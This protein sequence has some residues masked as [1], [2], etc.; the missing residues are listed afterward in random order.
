MPAVSR[1]QRVAAAI[2]EHEPEKLYTRNRGMLSMGKN[3]LSK[4]ASTKGA[5]DKKPSPYA[6]IFAKK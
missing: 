1:N 5:K 2:A 4:F 3:E 6:S